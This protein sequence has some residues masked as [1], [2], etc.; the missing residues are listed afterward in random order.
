ME[1]VTKSELRLIFG[2]RKLLHWKYL[3]QVGTGLKVV[4]DGEP[5]IAL[6]DMASLPR[7]KSNKTA[8][9]PT[10]PLH[11]VG[12]DIGYGDGTSPGGTDMHSLSW[13]QRHDTPGHM[14]S[15][16]RQ[17]ET[18]ST[19]YGHSLST[20]VVSLSASDATSIPV[21]SRGT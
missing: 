2:A 7:N 11:T 14:A 19:R 16:Q 17:A 21:L 12:M 5:T 4:D 15:K 8:S 10:K 6:S 1:R 3:E 20:R 13:T 9:R 18:S